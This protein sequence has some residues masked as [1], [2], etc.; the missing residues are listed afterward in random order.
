MNNAAAKKAEPPK[1]ARPKTPTPISRPSNAQGESTSKGQ[2][3]QAQINAAGEHNKK[4]TRCSQSSSTM[5]QIPSQESA[6]NKVP[7]LKLKKQKDSGSTHNV[8]SKSSARSKA[9]SVQ[10]RSNSVSKESCIGKV[11]A[12]KV[13]Q[14]R[15]HHDLPRQDTIA[16]GGQS[17]RS[18]NVATTNHQ[19]VKNQPRPSTKKKLLNNKQTT[20]GSTT[21]RTA[22]PEKAVQPKKTK[23]LHTSESV[24][25]IQSYKQFLKQPNAAKQTPVSSMLLNLKLAKK[26]IIDID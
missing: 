14:K 4:G 9:I 7:A 16:T 24:P 22:L 8:A 13:V 1:S 2:G 5:L 19:V 15:P 20:Q 26:P 17:H 11:K 25:Q 10:S 21:P 3:G 12:L 6:T 23:K 18:T